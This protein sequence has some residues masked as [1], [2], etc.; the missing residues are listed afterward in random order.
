MSCPLDAKH[1]TGM[2][3]NHRRF[4]YTPEAWA[5]VTTQPETSERIWFRDIRACRRCTPGLYRS[6]TPPGSTSSDLLQFDLDLPE[7]QVPQLTMANPVTL[8]VVDICVD[9]S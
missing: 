6:T 4:K 7:G 8:H 1:S 5:L 9:Y 2:E 3:G